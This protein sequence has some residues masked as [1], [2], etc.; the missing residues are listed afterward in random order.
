MMKEMLLQNATAA[1][2]AI[3]KLPPPHPE[4]PHFHLRQNTLH[5]FD[6]VRHDNVFLWLGVVSGVVLVPVVAFM[7]LVGCTHG[8]SVRND[9]FDCV[10]GWGG[11]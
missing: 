10:G 4:H 7:T 11:L 5:P 3:I 2:P 8:S 1:G 9:V 6:V